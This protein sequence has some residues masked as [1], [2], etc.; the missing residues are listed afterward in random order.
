M[1]GIPLVML[2]GLTVWSQSRLIGLFNDSITAATKESTLP[3]DS[4]DFHIAKRESL[5]FFD[6]IPS[7][8]WD[9]MKEKVKD[10]SPNFNTFYLPF[11]EGRSW[12][13][14]LPGNF[15]QN[16]YEPD[17]VCQHERR[18]G[19]LGDGGKWICDPHRISYQKDCLV[20]SVGSNNDFSFEEAVLDK[21]GHHCEIHTVSTYLCDMFLT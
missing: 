6:D 3:R 15:Y 11:K 12:R 13:A 7:R 18:I 19:K 17:F 20:Y 5:G 10:M 4:N 21:I 9:R 1:T 8:T 16:N 14:K 2:C